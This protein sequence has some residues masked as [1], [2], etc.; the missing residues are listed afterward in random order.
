MFHE[1]AY[2]VMSLLWMVFVIWMLVDCH[3]RQAD[4]FW[5]FVI[6]FFQPIGPVLYFLIHKLPDLGLDSWWRSAAG[7]GR[8]MREL[9][10]RAHR[11]DQAYDW[12]KLGDEYSDR[13]R[14]TQAAECYEK[15]LQRDPQFEEA[16]YG[17]GRALF[18]LDR[19]Q[20]ALDR[21]EPLA[22]KNPRYERGEALIAVARARRA[23]D[24]KE[25]ALDAYRKV[26]EN[27]TYTEVRYDYATLLHEMGRTDESVREMER[28][29]ADARDATGFH[30][31]NERRWARKARIFLKLRK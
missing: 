9:Q 1:I 24:R 4:F 8:R 5:F 18:W 25:D 19:H 3:R 10:A 12:S 6:F 28:I 21:L 30:R 15:A 13:R 29:I 17:L 20:E 23:L 31:S 7:G 22:L 14:W 26:L 27:Y 16:Q 11:M 2:S